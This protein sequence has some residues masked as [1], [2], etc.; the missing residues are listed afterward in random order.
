M[1]TD[2]V[3]RAFSALPLV[4]P[5][6][7]LL[8]LGSLVMTG[9]VNLSVRPGFGMAPLFILRGGAP[10]GTGDRRNMPVSEGWHTQANIFQPVMTLS[11]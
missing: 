9:D 5:V 4:G 3:A 8:A 6:C 1:A 2:F 7:L 11:W 10:R